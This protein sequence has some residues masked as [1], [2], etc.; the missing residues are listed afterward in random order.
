MAEAREAALHTYREI[1]PEQETVIQPDT[2]EADIVPADAEQIGEKCRCENVPN[3]LRIRLNNNKSV[4]TA[5]AIRMLGEVVQELNKEHDV[6]YAHL[7]KMGGKTGL[8]IKGL[9]RKALILRLK[10]VYRRR[11]DLGT[12][13]TA[14]DTYIWFRRENRPPRPDDS[15]RIYRLQPMESI[16][17]R[18]DSGRIMRHFG[19]DQIPGRFDRDDSMVMKSVFS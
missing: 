15:L 10:T 18:F 2:R 4:S 17:F 1:N 16:S 9:E 14:A 12:I 8:Q 3:G 11:F 6:C 5:T 7:M 13:K 19:A